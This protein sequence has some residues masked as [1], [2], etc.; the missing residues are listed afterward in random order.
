[1]NPN[2]ISYL[3][4]IAAFGIAASSAIFLLMVAGWTWLLRDG[5]GPNSIESS[6]FEAL[7]RFSRDFWPMGLIC[8][9]LF[10]IAYCIAPRRFSAKAGAT[11]GH[12][13]ILKI[14]K[15]SQ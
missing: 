15:T 11:K 7:R 13:D 9:A 14:G 2:Q 12:R 3:R 1:M 6:G 5:L 10:A 8:C 4:R